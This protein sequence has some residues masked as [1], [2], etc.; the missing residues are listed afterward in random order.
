LFERLR[1]GLIVS[2]QP[3]PG[4]PMDS[5]E[6]IVGFALAAIAGGAAALR[7]ES[8]AYVAAVR[9]ATSA[10]IVGLVKRDLEVSPVRITPYAAD[11][12]AL[13]EAGADIVAFDATERPRPDSVIDI[14]S[15][16]HSRGAL[17]MADCAALTDAGNALAAGAD[18]VGSTL[19]GYCGGPVPDEPDFQLIESLRELTPLV[20]AEG[21]IRTP[22]QAVEA[23]RRGAFCVAVG[24]AITRTEHVTSWFRHALDSTVGSLDQ[25]AH[26]A[27]LAIDIGGTK[28]L[29][30]LIEDG[31]ILKE[32]RLPTARDAGPDCWIA[33]IADKT[34]DLRGAYR[35]V[36]IAVT[37]FIKDGLWSAL[38]PSTLD[39]PDNFRLTDRLADAF[40][41]PAFA[42]NDAQAAAWGEYRHGAGARQDM[43][44]LTIS[45]GVGGGIV[46]NGR[47][48]RGLAGHFGLLRGPSGDWSVPLEDD[49]SGRWMEAAAAR[50]GHPAL[51]PEIF[52]AAKTG[53]TWAIDIVTASARKVALL[54]QDIQ[55]ALDPKRIIIGGGIGLAD[56]Y[57]D[58]V[59]GQ[60]AIERQW[61]RPVI[62]PA[63]L[64]G[65]AGVIGAADLA[66]SLD[67]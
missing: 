53:A 23:L 14:V 27:V 43:V 38:N 12:I 16:I 64:G 61:L 26:S 24:S 31:K 44:F 11:A 20:I 47:L 36:A 30:A 39:I 37:G 10:P 60:L 4:G 3:V 7:I 33:A 28:V 17:A 67:D 40:G 13:A 52:A 32:L 63:G 19:S 65:H 59:R 58:R 15:A 57:L 8:I 2:C 6:M 34:K 51:A 49:V 46:A 25:P 66:L 22:R 18:C 62:A 21:R 42:V 54:A 9:R 48:L 50:A 1:R 5:A 41:V 45:T 55:F 29:A 35:Q 56:G